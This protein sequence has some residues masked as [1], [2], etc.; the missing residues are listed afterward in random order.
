MSPPPSAGWDLHDR[1]LRALLARLDSDLAAAGEK[2]EQL[3][4]GLVK[5]FER[6][7]ATVPDVCADAAID[8]IARK[9]DRGEDVD[10]VFRFAHGVA[11][12]VWLEQGRRPQ[13]REVELDVAFAL[14][15]QAPTLEPDDPRTPCFEECLR[16]LES[17]ARALI[18]KYYVDTRPDRI[19]ARASL[20]SSLGLTPNALRSRAQRIRDRLERCTIA[21]AG[22]PPLTE[23]HD[24]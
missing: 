1:A 22:K 16:T 5:L 9:L 12:L 15:D 7:G 13:A 23:D 20:A 4:R 3:R 19:R 17:E 8:R 18:L 2:Y 21:C 6:R 11:R 24:V 14:P 10:D